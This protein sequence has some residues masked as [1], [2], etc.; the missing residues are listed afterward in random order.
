MTSRN[1][2]RGTSA[3][4]VAHVRADA[5][6]QRL[7]REQADDPEERRRA[8][9]LVPALAPAWQSGERLDLPIEHAEEHDGLRAGLEQQLAGLEHELGRRRGERG[10]RRVVE[11]LEEVD[12]PQVI[13]GH[14]CE[15]ISRHIPWGPW[16]LWSMSNPTPP[17]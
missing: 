7:L 13:R 15:S 6:L 1:V 14:P 11:R 8:V 9:E 17:T 5:D 10:E 16:R 12:D 3:R 4:R 2:A